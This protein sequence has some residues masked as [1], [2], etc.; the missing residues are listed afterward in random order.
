MRQEA[1]L[2]E[3]DFGQRYAPAK[4]HT[5]IGKKHRNTTAKN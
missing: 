4:L 5:E 2:A 3:G 1:E